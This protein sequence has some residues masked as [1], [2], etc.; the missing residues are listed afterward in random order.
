MKARWM[1]AGRCFDP[2]LELPSVPGPS[3]DP[4]AS[5]AQR[6]EPPLPW[7]TRPSATGVARERGPGWD[8]A[9]EAQWQQKQEKGMQFQQLHLF[10]VGKVVNFSFTQGAEAGGFVISA[11][12]ALGCLPQATA[13]RVSSKPL[14]A[15]WCAW[16]IVKKGCCGWGCP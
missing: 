15:G 8:G 7:P 12:L 1:V 6:C 10:A 4:G 11:E 2:H 14:F 16:L 3:C 13:A 5:S 9:Q